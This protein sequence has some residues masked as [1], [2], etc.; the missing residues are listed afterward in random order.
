M[1]LGLAKC[2]YR[3]RD[4]FASALDEFDA[5]CEQH[6]AEMEII[7]PA[8]VE[9]FGRA[10]LVDMYRQ[11]AIRCQKARDWQT[12]A[13]WAERGLAFYGAEAARPEAVEDL[14]KRLAHAQAKM[15]SAAASAARR[16]PVASR[17]ASPHP[18]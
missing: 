11:A 16:E 13:A 15:A 4:A 1:L 2:L 8:L 5:V 7:R 12:T 3:S 14:R 9:K 18:R 17:A 6:H 10:P